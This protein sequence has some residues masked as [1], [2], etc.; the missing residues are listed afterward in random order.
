MKEIEHIPCVNCITLPI[1][2]NIV[3]RT[4]Q[5][6][7]GSGYAVMFSV[8][9]I[10]KCCILR[11]WLKSNPNNEDDSMIRYKEFIKFYNMNSQNGSLLKPSHVKKLLTVY[12]NK[13]V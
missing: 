1:C 2:S 6:P 11:T 10:K 3:D 8:A 5:L 13:T 9:I 7:W 12:L 4:S